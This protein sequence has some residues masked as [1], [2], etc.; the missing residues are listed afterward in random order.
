MA[1]KQEDVFESDEVRELVGSFQQSMGGL[2]EQVSRVIIGQS[3]VVEHLLITLLV[4]GHCLITGMPGTAKTRSIKTLS[5]L[6]ESQ[7]SRVQFT[8]DL[9]PSD[10]TGSEIYRISCAPCH[11]NELQG[12]SGPRL[13]GADAPSIDLDRDYFVQTVTR[14]RGRMPAFSSRLSDEQIERVVDFVLEQQGR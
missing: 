11:G 8:P 4:G 2:R 1:T 13:G 3:H 10:I 5:Q 6:L 12:R 9:L 7:F 14:G